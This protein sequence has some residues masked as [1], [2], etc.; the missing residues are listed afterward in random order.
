MERTYGGLVNGVAFL[1][2]HDFSRA[3]NVAKGL[4]ALAPE[5]ICNLDHME[6]SYS[7][8]VNGVAFLKGHDFSRARKAAKDRSALAAEG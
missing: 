3:A 7:G 4:W 6:R 1:K 2:G 5:N 8:L